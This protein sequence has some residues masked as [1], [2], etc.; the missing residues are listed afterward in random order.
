M[1]DVFQQ[2]AIWG[3]DRPGARLGRGDLGL[4]A[5]HAQPRGHQRQDHGG[6]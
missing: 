1:C 3:G 2:N 4:P 5:E 6:H